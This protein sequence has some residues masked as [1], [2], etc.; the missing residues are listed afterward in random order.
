MRIAVS[1]LLAGCGFRAGQLGTDQPE[2]GPGDAVRVADA[3]IDARPDAPPDARICPPAPPDCHLFTCSGS[4]HCYYSCGTT[5]KVKWGDA[6]NACTSKA[7]GC[8]ATLNDASEQACITTNAMPTFPNNNFV[9]FGFYQPSG[10]VEPAGGWVWQCPP[11]TYTA[12]N[13]GQPGGEPNNQGGN[14]NCAA[15]TDGGA[16]FDSNCDEDARYVCELP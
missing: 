11:S 12:P 9:W 1:L 2:A 14:E 5:G 8:I 7:L 15:M 13:W 4:S 16:W 6:K 10:S 3:M